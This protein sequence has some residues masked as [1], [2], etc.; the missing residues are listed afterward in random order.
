METGVASGPHR[1]HTFSLP[2]HKHTGEITPQMVA[3]LSSIKD[4]DLN[5]CGKFVLTG[6]MSELSITKVDLS[7]M[8]TLEGKLSCCLRPRPKNLP[9]N[10]L[11]FSPRLPSIPTP[12][13]NI[14]AFK[15]MELTSLNLNGCRNLTG[16]F[17][18]RWGMVGGVKIGNRC[19][20]KAS[21]E[22]PSQEPS[23]F[24][25][26]PSLHPHF[27]RQHRCVQGHG[28][29]EALPRTVQSAHW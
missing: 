28:T 20:L 24:L 7:N 23:S 15:D 12:P 25:P 16:V 5:Y 4:K 8:N 27:P 26:T 29:Q 18:L 9:R 14:G 3:W 6:D 11:H 1:S 2:F 10:L 22:E 21:C 19:C 13:G 17:G